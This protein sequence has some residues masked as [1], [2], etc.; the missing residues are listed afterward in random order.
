[1]SVFVR[2][3]YSES[4]VCSC[5]KSDAPRK[6]AELARSEIDVINAFRF[7]VVDY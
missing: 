5:A 2:R 6:R 7:I 3:L 4:F 1:M